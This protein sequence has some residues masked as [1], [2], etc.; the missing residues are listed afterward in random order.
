LGDNRRV[1]R[2]FQFGDKEKI[3]AGRDGLFYEG[4]RKSAASLGHL[5][6]ARLPAAL[7]IKGVIHGLL[8]LPATAEN[9]IQRTHSGVFDFRLFR[10]RH[11]VILW[12]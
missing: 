11:K 2:V 1:F 5:I 4:G 3:C 7:N 6:E 10:L 9:F 12:G 8:F